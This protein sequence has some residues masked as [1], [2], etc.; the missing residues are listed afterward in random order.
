M[1]SSELLVHLEHRSRNPKLAAARRRE[2][3][4]RARLSIRRLG[5][6]H[7]RDKRIGN[8]LIRAPDDFTHLDKRGGRRSR[9]R[10]V[11][12]PQ[13]AGERD[14]KRESGLDREIARARRPLLHADDG[15]EHSCFK[16]GRLFPF[17]PSRAT[18]IST[19]CDASFPETHRAG[20]KRRNEGG[21]REISSGWYRYRPRVIIRRW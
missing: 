1:E 21:E 13:Y 11:F 17:F 12:N 15:S 18:T 19:S 6:R 16:I 7:T 14:E 4:S 5:L 9:R 3:H 10:R 20:T 2:F 8:L